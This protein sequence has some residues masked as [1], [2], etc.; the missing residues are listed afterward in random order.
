[1]PKDARLMSGGA[2]L[3]QSPAGPSNKALAS[4]AMPSSGG[5]GLG[6]G[7]GFVLGNS[8]SSVRPPVPAFEPEAVPSRPSALKAPAFKPRVPAVRTTTPPPSPP[9]PAPAP[10]VPGIQEAIHQEAI[11]KVAF[12]SADHVLLPG[13]I[14]KP[15]DVGCLLGWLSFDDLYTLRA[16]SRGMHIN[17]EME[18]MNRLRV[19]RYDVELHG[20]KAKPQYSSRGRVVRP[21]NPIPEIATRLA[22]FLR[23]FSRYIKELHLETAPCTLLENN[24]LLETLSEVSVTVATFPADGWSSNMDRK[25]VGQ[26]LK[27]GTVHQFV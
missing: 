23:H 12:Q 8:L 25:R 10:K 3:M 15:Q 21:V 18:L 6:G 16:A 13:L 20:F 5:G 11:E 2:L 19:F 17:R 4:Q 9:T 27:A 22:N 14:V 24:T 26:A 7:L 1:M